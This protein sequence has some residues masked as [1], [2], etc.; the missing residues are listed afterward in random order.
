MGNRS[1][2]HGVKPPRREADHSPQLEPRSRK[3]GFIHPFPTRLHDVFLN[4]LSTRITLPYLA[5]YVAV[6][7]AFFSEFIFPSS[8]PFPFQ[9]QSENVRFCCY[10]RSQG[11]WCPGRHSNWALAELQRFPLLQSL[12]LISDLHLGVFSSFPCSELA[13]GF[14]IFQSKNMFSLSYSAIYWTYIVRH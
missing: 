14:A 10:C 11:S 12:S 1:S 4:Y 7:Y 3:H 5:Y 2:F 13:L 8:D 6:Y 9:W